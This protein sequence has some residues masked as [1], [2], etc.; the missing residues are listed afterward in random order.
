MKEIEIID[1][2]CKARIL[3][4]VYHHVVSFPATFNYYN[5]FYFLKYQGR[6]CLY[7]RYASAYLKQSRV[8]NN[9]NTIRV[10]KRIVEKKNLKEDKN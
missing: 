2:Q 8:K 6:R 9:Y 1:Y 7:A 10:Q 4:D 3:Q 5:V